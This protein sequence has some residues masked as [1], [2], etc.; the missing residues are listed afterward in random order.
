MEGCLPG[1]V[2][3]VEERITNILEHYNQESGSKFPISLSIGS[4]VC[5]GSMKA[6]SIDELLAMTDA[7]LYLQKWH[8]KEEFQ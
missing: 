5:D 6:H 2:E 8:C 1:S 7:H 4:L 3:A